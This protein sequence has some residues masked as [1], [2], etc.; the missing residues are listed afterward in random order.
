VAAD[1]AAL[2]TE[3]LHF[4]D[5][6]WRNIKGIRAAQN[7]F[8]DL[9]DDAGDHA[10]AAAAESLTKPG[11]DEPLISR[12]FD[13]AQA[14]LF[15][16]DEARWHATRYSDGTAFGVWY[17]SLTLE[18]TVY[19]SVYHWL[20]FL[21]DAPTRGPGVEMIGERRVFTADCNGLLADLRAK[22]KLEPRLVDPTDY[23]FTHRVGR[24]AFEQGVNGLLA[25]SAR[26]RDG[27]NGAILSRHVL[28]NPRDR[29]Y[30][31]YRWI[32]G[33]PTVRVERRPGRTWLKIPS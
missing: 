15:P 26:H 20:R 21:R 8:D 32:V 13:Y 28:S 23:S 33:E 24:Y 31:T 18:T 9:S 29:C 2:F 27:V 6:L 25:P 19:E 10:V 1:P 3:T 14:I 22:A 17:G 11:G 4:R 5:P 7:L 16:F 12:P 30:L